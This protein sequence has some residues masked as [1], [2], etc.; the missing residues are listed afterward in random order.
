MIDLSQGLG[1]AMDG[2]GGL[3]ED[4]LYLS[5]SVHHRAGGTHLDR[6]ALG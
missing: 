1:F 2:R 5:L 3:G 4:R 6:G